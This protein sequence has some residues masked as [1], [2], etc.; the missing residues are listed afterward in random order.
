VI[1]VEPN[2]VGIDSKL[3]EERALQELRN[4]LRDVLWPKL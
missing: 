2:V 4:K 3:A 1:A